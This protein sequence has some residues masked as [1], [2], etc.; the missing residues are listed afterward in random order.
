MWLVDDNPKQTAVGSNK[1]YKTNPI[2]GG[3]GME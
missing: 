2:H 1:K 3:I